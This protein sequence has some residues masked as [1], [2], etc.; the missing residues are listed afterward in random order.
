[1]IGEDKAGG[2]TCWWQIIDH[3]DLKLV[4]PLPKFLAIHTKAVTEAE[5][6]TRLWAEGAIEGMTP[7]DYDRVLRSPYNSQ[8]RRVGMYKELRARSNGSGGSSGS[9]GW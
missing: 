6:K 7:E 8:I 9:S 5:A 2:I 4:V 3:P 1:M